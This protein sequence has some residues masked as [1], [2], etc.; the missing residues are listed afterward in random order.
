[1]KKIVLQKQ[2]LQLIAR[3]PPGCITD[4]DDGTHVYFELKKRLDSHQGKI[5]VFL[6]QYEHAISTCTPEYNAPGIKALGL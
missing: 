2:V 5:D 3:M 6:Q 4:Q 1:M